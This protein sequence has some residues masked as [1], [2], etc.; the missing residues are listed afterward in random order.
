M[1]A[2]SSQAAF[3]MAHQ[4]T[5]TTTTMGKSSST[6]NRDVQMLTSSTW[7]KVIETKDQRSVPTNVVHARKQRKEDKES[8]QSN[9]SD[10][11]TC[12]KMAMHQISTEDFRKRSREKA[13]HRDFQKRRELCQQPGRQEEAKG[14]R[15][16]IAPEANGSHSCKRHK[17]SFYA[18]HSN[19]EGS[20]DIE[21]RTTPT[22]VSKAKALEWEA[23]LYRRPVNATREQ[24]ASWLM[25]ALAVSDKCYI[26]MSNLVANSILSPPRTMAT[27]VKSERALNL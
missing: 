12:H 3:A 14:K 21:T 11:E 8:D 1:T 18:R 17:P 13:R 19:A 7:G 10:C 4:T 23:V 25:H 27:T 15:R 2:Q 16:M 6:M 20:G 24:M 9:S 26:D 5:A 22:A